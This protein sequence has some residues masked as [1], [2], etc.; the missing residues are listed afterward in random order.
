MTTRDVSCNPAVVPVAK[1]SMK[2]SWNLF[3]WLGFLFSLAGFFS[4]LFFI[5]FPVTRDFPWANFVIFAVSAV[6]LVAGL[7]RAFR[8]PDTYRGK[9]FGSIFAALG[10]LVFGFF[11]YIVFHELYQLPA[12]TGAPTVGQK[13]PDFTLPDQDNNPVPLAD[14]IS[15]REG[16]PRTALLI[17]YRGFW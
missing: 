3:L 15:G 14:L 12:S 11:S 4:Y 1:E 5:Q 10:L 17:F 16:K 13:A 8:S 2:R 6:F 7:R 9:I